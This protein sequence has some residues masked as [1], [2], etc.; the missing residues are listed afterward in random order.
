MLYSGKTK[1]IDFEILIHMT[2][3][4]RAGHI[5]STIV[6]FKHYAFNYNYNWLLGYYFEEDCL[7][8]YCKKCNEAFS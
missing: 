6:I 3:F 5:L 8:G 7:P 4:H 2:A 1:K